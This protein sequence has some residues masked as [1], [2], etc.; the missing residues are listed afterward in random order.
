V[1]AFGFVGW[2]CLAIRAGLSGFGI[3]LGCEV[4]L[5]AKEAPATNCP[6]QKPLSKSGDVCTA[7]AEACWV[8]VRFV[9]TAVVNTAT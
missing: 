4:P 9:D 5:C 8:P 1:T 6:A 3:K 7:R 2:S